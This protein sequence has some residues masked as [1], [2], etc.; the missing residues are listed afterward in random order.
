MWKWLLGPILGFMVSFSVLANVVMV[1]QTLS[2]QGVSL[3]VP[4]GFK[5]M[6]EAMKKVKYPSSH[7]PQ[8]VLTDVSSKVNI[9]LTMGYLPLKHEQVASYK[10]LLIKMMRNYHPVAEHVTVDKTKDAWL[11]SFTSQAMD[12]DIHNVMLITSVNDKAAILAFNCT[13]DIWN[14]YKNTARESLLSA[15]FF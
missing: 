14:I 7:S 3:E 11:L 8:V 6:D 5:P 13:D 12:A 1:R 15:H 9:A 2:E 10:D 4:V